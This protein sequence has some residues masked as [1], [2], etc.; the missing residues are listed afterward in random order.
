MTNQY[1][2]VIYKSSVDTGSFFVMLYSELPPI[3]FSSLYRYTAT[4]AEAISNAGYAGFK[5]SVWS[6]TLAVDFD[7]TEAAEQAEEKLKSLGI[8]F[9]VWTTGN[10]GVHIYINRPHVPSHLLPAIDKEWVTANLPG[11]DLSIYHN[12]A[13]FRVPGARHQKTG[14]KKAILRTYEGQ[15]L[16]LADTVTTRQLQ[17]NIGGP[18]PKESIFTNNYI[19]SLSVPCSE[20]ERHASLL[21]LGLA[22]KRLGEPVDFIAR[23]LSHVNALYQPPKDEGELERLLQFIEDAQLEQREQFE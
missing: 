7:T 20:G 17:A 6:P 13:M 21:H 1:D 19:M 18:R 3:G 23:W 4:D 16:L 12:V 2:H 10:R 22:L 8:A 5:G 11:A 9:E 14:N 15:P